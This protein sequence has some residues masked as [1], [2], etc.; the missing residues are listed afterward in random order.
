M[1]LS[2]AE[3]SLPLPRIL[4]NEVPRR[5]FGQAGKGAGRR[6]GGLGSSGC[7]L[8]WRSPSS[9]WSR[10][11]HSWPPHP[12]SAAMHNL[13]CPVPA[14]GLAVLRPSQIGQTAAINRP[15]PGGGRLGRCATGRGA[16]GCLMV[17]GPRLCAIPSSERSL[18][19]G[20]LLVCSPPNL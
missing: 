10:E 5:G 2:S 6:A 11:M 9:S 3:A 16:S 18:G 19:F 13:Q 17:V 8:Q 15:A 20:L 4:A 1:R 7:I 14:V 12:P